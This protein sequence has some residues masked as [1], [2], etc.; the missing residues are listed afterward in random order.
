MI[1]IRITVINKCRVKHR[2][3][4]EQLELT[5]HYRINRNN[6]QRELKQKNR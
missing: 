4:S 2:R 1:N 6:S 5:A 3:A